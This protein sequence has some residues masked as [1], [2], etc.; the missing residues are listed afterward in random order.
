MGAE[1]GA[2][3]AEAR[4]GILSEEALRVGCDSFRAI[5]RHL[6]EFLNTDCA[7]VGIGTPG[8]AKP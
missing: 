2:R 7:R 5:T 3:L 1:S 4:R 6:S 8:R